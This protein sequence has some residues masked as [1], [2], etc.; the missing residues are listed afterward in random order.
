M[1]EIEGA[2]EEGAAYLRG[3]VSLYRT[4]TG[5]KLDDCGGTR[6]IRVSTDLDISTK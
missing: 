5:F 4:G 6:I 3:S 2:K 1:G